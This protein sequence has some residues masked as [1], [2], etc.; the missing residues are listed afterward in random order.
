MEWSRIDRIGLMRF[1]RTVNDGLL[2]LGSRTIETT[3]Y[4]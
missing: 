3:D 2:W 1:P 4:Q